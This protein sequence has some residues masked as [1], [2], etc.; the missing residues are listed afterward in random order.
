MSIEQALEGVPD[1]LVPQVVAAVVAAVYQRILGAEK[2]QKAVAAKPS[3]YNYL[4]RGINPTRGFQDIP[5]DWAEGFRS[6]PP[7]PVR[8]RSLTRAELSQG[9]ALRP[10]GS[11]MQETDRV[12][13]S[14]VAKH[15]ALCGAWARHHE[16]SCPYRKPREIEKPNPTLAVWKRDRRRAQG[17]RWIDPGD[18]VPVSGHPEPDRP[19]WS[20][21]DILRQREA[22]ARKWKPWTSEKDAVV[23]LEANMIVGIAGLRPLDTPPVEELMERR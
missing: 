9:S 18:G 14:N 16:S 23:M 2:G 15:R 8:E 10:F 1:E 19:S 6:A 5:E 7:V 12:W 13:F 22:A 17:G 11:Q 4:P 21:D 3:H 20:H